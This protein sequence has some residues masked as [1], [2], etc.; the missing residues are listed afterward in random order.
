MRVMATLLFERED[1]INSIQSFRDV[2]QNWRGQTL[3]I[4]ALAVSTDLINLLPQ[5][6]YRGGQSLNCKFEKK[7]QVF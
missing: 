1:K 3:E 4:L 7:T 6:S 5:N 2:P